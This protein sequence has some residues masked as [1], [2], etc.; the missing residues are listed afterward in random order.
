MDLE[1]HKQNELYDLVEIAEK[2]SA[3]AKFYSEKINTYKTFIVLLTA[4][5][6]ISGL[7]LSFD[8]YKFNQTYLLGII[9][10]LIII[11]TLLYMNLFRQLTKFRDELRIENEI[12]YKLIEMIYEV[13]NVNKY[14]L[15][16]TMMELAIIEMRLQ[17][18]KFSTKYKENTYSDNS[19]KL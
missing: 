17:R 7:L 18:I 8:I 19:L 1:K 13:K 16:M 12:L 14:R 9:S 11:F 15:N 2:S 3:S 5:I 6:A 10:F 4:T